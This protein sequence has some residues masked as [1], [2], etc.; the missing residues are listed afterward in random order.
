MYEKFYGLS[1]KPFQL[2]PDPRFY[3]ASTGHSRAFAYLK[4][5]VYQGD[6]FIVITGDIGAGKTTLLRALMD[7][8]DTER[9]V[10]AHLVS[11][12]LDA[13]DLLQSVCSAFG[14]PL[15]EG[16]KAGLLSG[17]ESFLRSLPDQDKR[18]L[19]IVDEAQNLTQRAME[20]LRMLSNFQIGAH[21]LLQSFLVG[22]PE[23]RETM[24][25][26]SLQQL[27]QRVIATCHLGPLS[28]DETR[29][30]VL[31]RLERVGWSGDPEVSESI[32]DRLQEETAGVP[33]AVNALCNRLLFGAFLRERH[34]IGL[35][36][37]DETIREM[38]EDFGPP[39]HKQLAEP[40]PSQS[41]NVVRPLLPA[42]VTVR[43]DRIEKNV[44]A[45]Y[46]L[47]QQLARSEVQ[48]RGALSAERR[49]RFGG[50]PPR[51]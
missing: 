18:A 6:G 42:A 13:D 48:S 17:F 46:E 24:R 36:D 8:V 9:I 37:L 4:Y 19:L 38:R 23:L 7:E 22:Q 45:A 14:L 35:I 26:P 3:F 27:R 40:T 43:L 50:R 44:A 33:R 39:Q 49:P 31:H 12:Q 25:G 15:G 21:S 1:G 10:V 29:G 41:G 47:L 34:T 5:G 28:R 11:T 51:A 2:N 30:Y 32:F 16:G 20:E